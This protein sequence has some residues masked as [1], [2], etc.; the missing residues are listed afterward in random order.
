MSD[1]PDPTLEGIILGFDF[2]TKKIGVAVGQTV[3]K[4]AN[5]LGLLRA[6][7]GE[8]RW[9]SV[10]KLIEEWQPVALVVG[11]PLNMDGTRQRVTAQAEQFAKALKERFQLP[12][13]GVDERLTTVEARDR[14]FQEQGY[15]GLQKT[16]MDAVAAKIILEAWLQRGKDTP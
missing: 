2:G 6:N 11:I 10:Q 9:E 4:T 7:Q 1:T 16:A 12:V 13:F 3:T 5:P 15:K 8:P 14:V